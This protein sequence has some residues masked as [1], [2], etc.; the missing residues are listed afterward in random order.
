MTSGLL[1]VYNAASG[2]RQAWMDA[3]HKW[4][5]PQTYPC[6]LCALTH[7]VF[8]EKRAWTRF[9]ESVTHP[10]EFLH[11]DEFR[12]QYASKFGA[13]FKLPVILWKGE[14]GLEVIMSAAE[15][16]AL[17]SLDQLIER[18]KGLSLT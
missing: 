5:S 15:I 4:V 10:M 17:D 1:F 11:A 3:L 16:A 18:L 8:Q 6:S 7:G 9:R 2:Q 14:H 12:Q 13:R